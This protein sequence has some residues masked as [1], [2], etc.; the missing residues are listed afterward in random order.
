MKDLNMSGT[1]KVLIPS[2]CWDSVFTSLHSLFSINCTWFATYLL[3]GLWLQSGKRRSV[4]QGEITP[5]RS[6][7]LHFIY[8]LF[9][10]TSILVASFKMTNLSL[11]HI[12]FLVKSSIELYMPICSIARTD[13]GESQYLTLGFRSADKPNQHYFIDSEIRW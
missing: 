13:K 7:H 8:D 9:N 2:T 5:T 3:R 12:S 10:T 4:N 1:V 6:V 11:G